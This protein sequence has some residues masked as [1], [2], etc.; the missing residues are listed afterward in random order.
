M[1]DGS[2]AQVV[3]FREIVET[4]VGF[5][6]V[7]GVDVGRHTPF[8]HVKLRTAW[9]EGW[10]VTGVSWLG[11]KLMQSHVCR[12]TGDRYVTALV[13]TSECGFTS[14]LDSGFT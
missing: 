4:N 2:G 8:F 9:G 5:V 13:E 7:G 12:T 3:R 6:L 11:P 14:P 10:I 1:A